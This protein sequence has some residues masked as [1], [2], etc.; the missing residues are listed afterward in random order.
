M[1]L[2]GI[3]AN[4]LM[5]SVAC[6]A[7]ILVLLLLL[8]V[9]RKRV[10]ARSIHVIFLLLALRLIVPVQI[11]FPDPVLVVREPEVSVTLPERAEDTDERLPEPVPG[12]ADLDFS[13]E[14]PQTGPRR[15]IPLTE[16]AAAVW[17]V[18]V[19]G[20]LLYWVLSYGR[21]RRS[22]LKN[23]SAAEE[24][25]LRVLR[26]EAAKLS[27]N[28]LPALRRCQTVE[29]AMTLGIFRPVILLGGEAW[30]ERTLRFVL[31]HELTHFKHGDIAAKWLFALA[32]ALHWFDPLVWLMRREAHRNLELYCDEAVVRGLSTEERKRYGVI[33]LNAAESVRAAAFST[34]FGSR[35]KQLRQRLNGLFA[36]KRT[37]VALVCVIAVCIALV[38]G[39]VACERE[40]AT[41]A[42]PAAQEGLDVPP[43]ETAQ[44]GSDADADNPAQLEDYF[45][46]QYDPDI[47]SVILADLTGDDTEEM[48]VLRFADL[49][50]ASV[51]LREKTVSRE[52]FGWA[53][54][55][56]YGVVNG[57]VTLFLEE[58]VS[59]SHVGWGH[60][61]L[62]ALT[63]GGSAL[64]RFSPYSIQGIA[65][66][67]YGLFR[68]D[69]KGQRVDLERSEVEF[70]LEPLSLMG[71]VVVSD[72]RATV[73]EFLRRA[74][75]YQTAGIPL[76]AYYDGFDKADGSYATDFRY[77]NADPADAFRGVNRGRV[78]GEPRDLRY[79]LPAWSIDAETAMEYLERSVTM[80]EDGYVFR[81]TDFEGS[82]T[83]EVT[84]T[85]STDGVEY[86]PVHGFENTAWERGRR[87]ELLLE[88]GLYHDLC[89][90]AVLTCDDG[91]KYERSIPL[92][93]SHIEERWREG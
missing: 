90:H 17:L 30:E 61:Y 84:G 3:F 52:E 43:V 27:L 76:L 72:S 11:A 44:S 35:E 82:W 22:L 45:Y 81:V 18:G 10:A 20:C 38:G 48:I 46:E 36:V 37:C 93:P 67:S 60:Y 2:S 19:G 40:E 21:A 51:S 80:T 49:E 41:E 74:E 77:W 92:D 32:C 1:S 58:A 9:M 24:D 56:V 50:D 8:P 62:C 42:G 47:C 86:A 63:D 15:S 23:A 7:V 6:G 33:L 65:S 4:V 59:S 89:I 12:E 88:P 39:L 54:L 78:E 69:E 75:E 26:S 5:I 57:E 16:I 79:F 66:Y 14:A 13:D 83:L 91:T 55:N 87:Y 73:E 53:G 64:F 28:R 71:E 25:E 70:A 85:V 31:R 34:R 68:F 29:S